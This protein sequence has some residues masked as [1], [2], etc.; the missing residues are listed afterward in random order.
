MVTS[1]LVFSRQ[2]MATKEVTVRE[3]GAR[4]MMLPEDVLKVCR[5]VNRSHSHTLLPSSLL[6]SRCLYRAAF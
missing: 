3:V 5:D 4:L 6:L 2:K 1:T